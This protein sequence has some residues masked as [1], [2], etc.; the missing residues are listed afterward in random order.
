[1]KARKKW[2]AIMVS[3]CML[4]GMS[5]SLAESP[6]TE[7]PV[8]SEGLGNAVTLTLDPSVTYQVME[9]FGF[10]GAMRNWSN[11]VTNPNLYY[12]EAWIDEILL[13]LGLTMWR[14]EVYPFIPPDTGH[15]TYDRATYG[16]QDTDW[17]RQKPMVKA[18]NDRAKEL[19]IPLRIILTAWTPPPQ[20]KSNQHSKSISGGDGSQ[21]T[22][23]AIGGHTGYLL[24]EH[25]EDYGR[26]WV[27]VLDM[28]KAE[29]VDVYGISLQNEPIFP[30]TWNSA[31][32]IPTQFV[33]MLKAAVPV[34]KEA[35]PDII[36]FGAE[37]MLEHENRGWNP[38]HPVIM[39]DAAARENLDA[40]AVHGYSDGAE[41]TDISMHKGFWE[42]E[43]ATTAPSGNPRWMTETS[44]YGNNWLNRQSNG[45]STLTLAMAIQSA[46]LYGDVSAWTFWQ[47]YVS[48][49]NPNQ[50]ELTS[51]SLGRNSK[52]YAASQH[53]YKY[54]RPGA[55]RIDSQV[56]GVPESDL[57]VTAF[58]HHEDETLVITLVNSSLNNQVLNIEGV[59]AME[60]DMYV[61]N[62]TDHF[63]SK[64]KVSGDITIPERSAVTLVADTSGTTVIPSQY[65][66]TFDDEGAKT[67]TKVDVGQTVSEPAN[68]ARA[69][70]IFNG[71]RVGSAD[72]GT[73]Y[74][75]RKPVLSNLTIY[76]SWIPENRVSTDVAIV[77]AVQVGGADGTADS[78]GIQITFN[79]AVT[80]LTA[81]DLTITGG[82]TDF[83]GSSPL[84]TGGITGKVV[85]GTTLTGSGDT[86]TVHLSS[87]ARGGIVTVG[88]NNFGTFNITGNTM[89]TVEV[90]KDNRDPAD[91]RTVTFDTGEG[92][93]VPNATVTVGQ[94]VDKPTPDPTREGYAFDGWRIGS[95]SGDAYNFDDPVTSDL[96]LFAAWVE[97]TLVSAT[98]SA[99]VTKLT[100]NMNDL[101]I[102]VTESYS[103][104]TKND[105]TV[106]LKINNN[107]AGTYQVGGYTVYVET[108]G[109]T[110]IH[111]IRIV[112]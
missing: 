45:H 23:I 17:A 111:D 110:Q 90:F 100:G 75:F 97:I 36:I 26:W 59:S 83:W 104:G 10:F 91:L 56:T 103:D 31:Y 96:T 112:N 18:L 38:Y 53:F 63:T 78:T 6:L 73:L 33:A 32:I 19:D 80:G 13:D 46:L 39:A 40:F 77:E 89:R 5:V 9:G 69:G 52:K 65:M 88:V 92:S 8:S 57:L 50:Y 24:P 109:N 105:I 25:F 102:T 27:E 16:I 62:A 35:Y 2:V 74:D 30:Q 43:K 99:Y 81:D 54:I 66:V 108:K 86:Y 72:R 94:T 44:G 29:G 49:T 28:Y 67:P 82:S 87:V 71:W 79:K 93:K 107:A 21:G 106:T 84:N 48:S 95:A 37:H 3:I 70:Y 34:I 14:N 20:W 85:K 51:Q 68:P 41:A 1:M 101:T 22:L 76:A 55:V 42:A 60:Y 64:G 15:T 12:S 61:T 98:P 4:M 7:A 58:T 47:G 11:S